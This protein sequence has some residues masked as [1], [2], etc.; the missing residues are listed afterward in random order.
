MS[1]LREPLHQPPNPDDLRRAPPATPDCAKVRGWLRDFVDGDLDATRAGELEEHV[2]G[3]RICAVELARTEHEAMRVRRLFASLAD[4]AAVLPDGFAA[5]VVERLVL[6][7]TSLVPKDALAR[8]VDAAMAREAAPTGR[9]GAA[10]ENG[11]EVGVAPAT[12]FVSALLLVLAFVFSVEV[13]DG[14]GRAPEGVPGLYVIRSDSAYTRDRRLGPGDGVGEQQSLRV[15]RGGEAQVEW[16]DPSQK[17]QPTAT[18]RVHGDGEVRLEEGKPLLVTGA[19]DIDTH[20]PVSIPMI[21]GSTLD[22]GIGEYTIS[23]AMRPSEDP[24][25]KMPTELLI[26]VEVKSGEALTVLR[27]GFAPTAVASGQVGIYQGRSETTV[28]PSGGWGSS[29]AATDEQ[30]QPAEPPPAPLLVGS[31]RDYLGAPGIGAAIGLQ[32][33]IGGWMQQFLLPTATDGSFQVPLTGSV[34]TDFVIASAIPTASR[35]DLGIL[36]PDAV[37]LIAYGANRMLSA[38]LGLALS[39]PVYGQVL[40]E[41]GVPRGNVLVVPCVVDDLFGMVLPQMSERVWTDSYGTFR[42]DRLPARLP[43]QQSLRLLLLHD[44]LAPTVLPIPE[45]GS[46]LAQ[47]PLPPATMRRLQRVHLSELPQGRTIEVLEELPGL[48]AGTGVRR[49]AVTTNAEGVVENFGVGFGPMWVRFPGQPEL[50][51][52][53]LGEYAGQSTYRPGPGPEV[54][55]SSVFR[56][57]DPIVGTGVELVTSFRHQDCALGAAAGSSAGDILQV[58]DGLGRSAAAQVFLVEATGPRD[59]ANVR[60]LGFTSAAG[61]IEVPLAG[62][63]GGLVAIASDGSC[64]MLS[65]TPGPSGG[66]DIE[67]LPTGRALLPPSLRPAGAAET[68]V[69]V[70]FARDDATLPG[71]SPSTVRYVGAATGWEAGDLLPGHYRVSVGSLHYHVTV[72]PGGFSPITQ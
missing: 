59:S 71:L 3:C 66:F 27:S 40:D 65:R 55:Q 29:S 38:S 34:D 4:P 41:T 63:S 42:C 49:R 13:F 6:D 43:P 10:R 39:A 23:A 70:V 26:E 25:A 52:L 18:L 8:A 32:C 37:R 7:E 20:R 24:L 60:F 68:L 19:V 72:P 14:F 64:G 5:R 44:E 53:F 51:S 45:R 54:P 31:A 17:P 33:G 35:R 48:P 47:L 50:Q 62:A 11:R 57:L 2:H 28:V 16:H 46:V 1:E 58:V 21:D 15:G 56:S 67:L 36:A 61:M 22:L 69:P 30:R 9:T 12:M